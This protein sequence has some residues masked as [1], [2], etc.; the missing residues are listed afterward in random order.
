MNKEKCVFRICKEN[1]IF[2]HMWVDKHGWVE[3]LN[4]CQY[5]TSIIHDSYFEE[6]VDKSYQIFDIRHIEESYK[7]RKELQEDADTIKT[8][9]KEVAR[10]KRRNLINKKLKNQEQVDLVL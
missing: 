5:H 8:Y 7:Y 6:M 10:N 4:L 3:N 9:L 2:T 1:A